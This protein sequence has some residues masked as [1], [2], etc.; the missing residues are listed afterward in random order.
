MGVV[1]IR[2]N[3]YAVSAIDYD[4]RIFYRSV[5]YVCTRGKKPQIRYKVGDFPRKGKTL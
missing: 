1:K 3:I 5:I 2:D 4:I